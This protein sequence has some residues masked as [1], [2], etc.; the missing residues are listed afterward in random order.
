[1]SFLEYTFSFSG[2]VADPEILIA[3]LDV[4]G[5][6][7]FQESGYQLIA[8]LPV[9][10]KDERLLAE[11]LEQVGGGR[12]IIGYT[13]RV[14]PDTNW[15][16]IWESGFKPVEIDDFVRIRASFHEQD[17][18]FVY[19]IV[20]DPKMSFG[21][22]HHATTRLMMRAMRT[23]N[24]QGKNVAD[25]GCGTSVL[26]ILASLMGASAVL[27]V[28]VD[29]WAV[30]NSRDNIEINKCNN[31][32]VRNGGIDV[33]GSD[34]FDMVLANINRNVL[35]EYMFFFSRMLPAGGNL[36]LS[37]IMLQDRE[38][39][40]E[41]ADDNGFQP[42]GSFSEENWCALVFRKTQA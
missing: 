27:A 41:S 5:Y 32:E 16:A 38:K 34:R 29:E 6:E 3:F 13:S 19:D 2:A 14:L 4:Y 1:M 39:I 25:L 22:G 18:T 9:S 31:I 33:A 12:S 37:G 7:G 26:G 23:L 17:T 35:L 42:A 24:F 20:I 8:Y 28:D 40:S 36:V 15:N 10:K 11:I 30:R 21:T